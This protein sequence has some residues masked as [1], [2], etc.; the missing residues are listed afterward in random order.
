MH[1]LT[2]QPQLL[3]SGSC[4]DSVRGQCRHS[5]LHNKPWTP[6]QCF[7][8]PLDWELLPPWGLCCGF[9]LSAF[10]GA[11]GPASSGGAAYPGSRPPRLQPVLV[12]WLLPPAPLVFLL[13]P[14][15]DSSPRLLNPGRDIPQE[16]LSLLLPQVFS[17]R[18]RNRL[19]NPLFP[20][21]LGYPRC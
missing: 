14:G 20:F 19:G 9:S 2:M 10:P 21:G 8:P 15:P 16:G 4:A 13:S 7:L 6:W 12:S 17:S 3:S 11:P 18:K 1:I 5:V